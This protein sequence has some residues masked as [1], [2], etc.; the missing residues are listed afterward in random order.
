M[1]A[2]VRARLAS[3]QQALAR[4]QPDQTRQ[5]VSK[6]HADVLCSLLQRTRG[7]DDFELGELMVEIS[8]VEWYGHSDLCRLLELVTPKQ[9]AQ[10]GGSRVHP[11]KQDFKNFIDFFTEKEWQEQLL[12]DVS[13]QAK[14]DLIASRIIWLGARAYTEE[15][16]R[17]A[18]LFWLQVSKSSIDSRQKQE[19]SANVKRQMDAMKKK[20]SLEKIDIDDLGT[21][22]EFFS[23]HPER[24][25]LIYKGEYPVPCKIDIGKLV[26]EEVVVP[27][28]ANESVK[29]PPATPMSAS[30]SSD[31]TA[32][33]VTL[34]HQ[35]TELMKAMGHHNNHLPTLSSE[36]SLKRHIAKGCARGDVKRNIAYRGVRDA[37]S[38]MIRFEISWCPEGDSQ[39]RLGAGPEGL[40]GHSPASSPG[41]FSSC[42]R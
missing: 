42:Y 22:E 4:E 34:V 37:R 5:S 6:A 8:Q 26:W 32:Q 13:L 41:A 33:I 10:H 30:S 1:A 3:A 16:K 11:K 7:I 39:P 27:C 29:R 19:L 17:R 14:L 40:A 23:D 28:R 20:S 36:H 9:V 2:L 35:Q 31:S 24:A 21:P 38:E 25:L 18:T 15:T 12:S